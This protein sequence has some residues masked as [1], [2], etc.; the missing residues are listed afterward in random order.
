MTAFITLNSRAL[1]FIHFC[2]ELKKSIN[3]FIFQ[4][5]K[6]LE[7]DPFC[8]GIRQLDRLLDDIKFNQYDARKSKTKKKR[9]EKKA[10]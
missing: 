7:D 9:K 3:S 10:T 8:A 5:I 2:S 4:R 1:L 6:I